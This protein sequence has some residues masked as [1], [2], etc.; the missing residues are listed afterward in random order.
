[1]ERREP[2]SLLVDSKLVALSW[3]KECR[4]LNKLKTELQHD[5]AI[6]LLGIY[7]GKTWSERIDTPQCSVKHYLQDQDMEAP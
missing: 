3:R 6:P 1:M 5:P 2:S 7:P 4:L